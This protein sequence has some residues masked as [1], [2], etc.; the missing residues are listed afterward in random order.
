[1]RLWPGTRRVATLVLTHRE[2]LAT[3]LLG[4]LACSAACG[5]ALDADPKGDTLPQHPDALGKEIT[6]R[7]IGAGETSAAPAAGT[8]AGGP[9]AK[10]T[11]SAIASVTTA[12]AN[13]TVGP[14]AQYPSLSSIAG[15]LSPGD[16]VDVLGDATYAGGVKFTRSGS[17]SAKI[18]IRGVPRNG[19]RPIVSGGNDGI[20]ANGDHYVFEGLEITG[21]TNRCFF[22]H[23]DDVTLRDSLVRDCPGHGVL[24]ADEG[25][26]SFTMEF[27]EVRK[28]GQNGPNTAGRQRHQVYMASDEKGHPH[29]IFRMQH[30]WVH[31]GGGGNNVKSRAERNE[32]Y[33]NW[34]ENAVY[35]ELELIGP[36][37]QDPT[38][39]REDSD[40]V[41]NVFV[42]GSDFYGVR[43]GGDGTGETKG[44]YRFVNNTFVMN[45]RRAAFRL[46]DG[47]ESLDASNNLFV[48][49]GGG[50]V[51]LF[52]TDDAKWSLGHPVLGGTNN[53]ISKDTTAPKEW[54]ANVLVDD[55]K[56]DAGFRP[57]KSS[58]ISGKGSTRTT[59]LGG[60][61]VPGP[62]PLPTSEPTNAVKPAVPRA[63]GKGVPSIGALEG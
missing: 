43:L 59:T 56:L 55:A 50:A 30:C 51:T 42:K 17:A 8:P 33:Y 3:A 21:S 4:A 63:A 25:S 28:T 37:G 47:I 22:Q 39:A 2:A 35:H 57:D 5:P 53:G 10:T 24:G 40:V 18:V 19:K 23:A 44:R 38:L 11:P 6:V 54:S 31:D 45:G 26:G 58:P 27:V 34:I 13:F 1:M 15:L 36:D 52:S 61:A 7:P 12:K 48:Q 32:I 9:D 41:G 16:V 62:L 20:E 46:M 60:N 49:K 29:S 14:G